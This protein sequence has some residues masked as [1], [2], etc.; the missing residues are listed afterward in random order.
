M[1][2][3][4]DGIAVRRLDA[5]LAFALAVGVGLSIGGCRPNE[6]ELAR[7]IATSDSLTRSR[8][9]SL[10]TADS[11]AHAD[12]V[13]RVNE[14]RTRA[15]LLAPPSACEDSVDGHPS[16][17]V[18][19]NVVEM[20]LPAGFTRTERVTSRRWAKPGSAV[21]WSGPGGWILAASVADPH[22]AWELNASSRCGATTFYGAP[23]LIERGRWLSDYGVFALI[24]PDS[25]YR[26]GIEAVA[27][28]VALQAELLHAIRSA[29][30]SPMWHP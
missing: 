8:A 13:A 18:K 20:Q 5:P 22:G 17:S 26:I 4:Q 10:A 2:R 24:G 29:R 15:A 16:V 11:L 19:S 28:S 9:D 23:I 7:A 30:V 14:S 25:T 27:N 3:W 1:R 12:S 21:Q 6:R